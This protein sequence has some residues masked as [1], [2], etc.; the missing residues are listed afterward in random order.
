LIP[1]ELSAGALKA[2]GVP[3]TRIERIANEETAITVD[4]ALW[5]A[6]TL[7]TFAQLWLNLQNEFDMH[8]AKSHRKGIGE[9]QPGGW[10]QGWLE[11]RTAGSFDPAATTHCF[12][13]RDGTKRAPSPQA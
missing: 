10:M 4:T 2:C 1:L 9:D 11:T 5:L 6:K 12:G 7:G 3:R 8:R 13:F